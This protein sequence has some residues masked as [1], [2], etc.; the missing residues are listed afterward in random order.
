WDYEGNL[1]V[2]TD[3]I[4]PD[5]GDVGNPP[6]SSGSLTFNGIASLPSFAPTTGTFADSIRFGNPSGG[7]GTPFAAGTVVSGTISV[8]LSGEPI[9]FL[10][11][12]PLSFD[13]V[14]GLNDGFTSWNRLEASATLVSGVPE[15]SS[16]LLLGLASLSL[17]LLRFRRSTNQSETMTV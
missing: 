11:V 6:Y 1:G 16:F 15:P 12:D 8:D 3:F 10:P 2:H 17:L 5:A 13:L 14:S 4:T 7:V 9:S